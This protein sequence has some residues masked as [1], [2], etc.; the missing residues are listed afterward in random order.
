MKYVLDTHTLVWHLTNDSRLGAQACA[1]LDDEN[2]QLIV[3][4]IV[5][6]EAK[7]IADRKRV[8]LAFEEILRAVVSDPR[9]TVLPLDIFIVASLPSNLDIHDGLIVATALYCREFFSDGV[10]I[11][12][13]DQAISHSGLAPTKW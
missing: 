1:I 9:C 10:A 8:P 6:A 2:S 7:F 3:P 4:V 12:T 11:L 13:K 5:L